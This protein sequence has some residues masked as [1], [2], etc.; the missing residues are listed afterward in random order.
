MSE[1]HT[2]CKVQDL[3]EGE[4]KTVAIGASW[5]L[6]SSSKAAP[7]AID[8]CCPHMGSAPFRRLCRERHRHLP[9][10]R[11]ALS[12][13]RRHLGRQ[14]AHQD[15][16][17]RRPRC[18]RR[19]ANPDR[20][21]PRGENAMSHYS[22]LVVGGAILLVSAVAPGLGQNTKVGK[23]APKLEP[24]AETRLLMEGLANANFRG[25]ERNLSKNP[26]DDPSWVFARGQALLIAET[27][28]LLMLRPPRNPGENTWMEAQHGVAHPGP[29]SGATD[30]RKKIWHAASRPCNRLPMHAINAIKVFA[31]RW[32][33]CR[34]RKPSRRRCARFRNRPIIDR[35]CGLAF[36]RNLWNTIPI[37]SFS[38]AITPLEWCSTGCETT[39]KLQA[40]D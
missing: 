11:L 38:W 6:S 27:A 20:Q 14:P 23:I 29:T 5:S 35:A 2:V 8:D 13:H 37:V 32:T 40:A 33:S 10:A 39:F 19:R 26:I 25:L 36:A 34:S 22:R 1:F 31:C 9:L 28:N 3:K 24:I 17:P 16:L 7:F 4:G 12:R 18:R 21:S 30:W 15:R